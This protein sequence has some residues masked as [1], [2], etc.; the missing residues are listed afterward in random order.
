MRISFDYDDTLTKRS[1]QILA[2]QLIKEGNELWIISAR[3]RKEPMMKLALRLGIPPSR[4]YAT[5]SNEEKVKKVLELK[6]DRHYDNN[7]RVI[8]ELGD[9]GKLI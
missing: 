3:N 1:N 5:G 2:Q 9:K 6:I 4:V 8:D 7:R